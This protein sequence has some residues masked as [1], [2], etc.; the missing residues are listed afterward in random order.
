MHWHSSVVMF[1]M[2]SHSF[3][4]PGKVSH[5]TL[6]RHTSGIGKGAR[7]P[8]VSWKTAKIDENKNLR[9]KKQTWSLSATV[10]CDMCQAQHLKL[11]WHCSLNDTHLL[12]SFISTSRNEISH[13]CQR[14]LSFRYE[15]L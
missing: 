13:Y 12:L 2:S 7:T 9:K 6:I 4:T 15:L 3:L 8:N 14:N 10:L 5:V 1:T 11:C